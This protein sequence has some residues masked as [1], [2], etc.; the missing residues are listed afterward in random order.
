MRGV[1]RVPDSINQLFLCVS[2]VARLSDM[3]RD[4]EADIALGGKAMLCLTICIL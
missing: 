3:G 2:A 1:Q 4:G